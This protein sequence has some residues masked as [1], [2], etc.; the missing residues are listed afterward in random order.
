MDFGAAFSFVTA[1][2]DWVKKMAIASGVVFVGIIT[3]G[4]ALI[5]LAGYSL[6][7][8]RR[9][10]E[11]TEPTLPEWSD[12]G[13]LVVDGLKVVA[14][15]LVWSLPLILLGACSGL[16]T[17]F[18]GNGD[19]ATASSIVSIVVACISLP[20]ALLLAVLEPAAIGH[21]AKTGELGQ[22]LN[23]ANAFKAVRAN[24]GAY[25]IIALVIIFV[26]PIIESIGALI[27]VIGLLPAV[28]YSAAL[29]G[30]LIGQAYQGA[31]E[32]GMME[33]TV[34]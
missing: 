15:G 25:V 11:G 33:P 6:A 30:H 1:D 34:A 12:F 24:V 16:A 22:S 17:T 27:C 32:S 9:V 19:T 23:P 31:E 4:L 3:F 7:I 2:K 18:M 29:L 5:P 13:K 14:I 10:I 26:I 21:L 28:G 8:S 20:Y